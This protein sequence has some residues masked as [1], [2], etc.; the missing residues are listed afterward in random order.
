MYPNGSGISTLLEQVAG[1]SPGQ[2]P[3]AALHEY[4]SE[5]VMHYPGKSNVEDSGGPTL[6]LMLDILV[7]P[8]QFFFW[9]NTVATASGTLGKDLGFYGIKGNGNGKNQSGRTHKCEAVIFFDI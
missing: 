2:V 8:D 1:R 3:H 4:F 5:S 6:T 9:N 7:C